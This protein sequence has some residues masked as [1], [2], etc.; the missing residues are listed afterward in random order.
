MSSTNINIKNIAKKYFDKKRHLSDLE[1]IVLL[2][3]YYNEMLENINEEDESDLDL[4]DQIIEEWIVNLFVPPEDSI[5]IE[6]A[7]LSV[8]GSK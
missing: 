8:L 2:Y 3:Y 7:A 4:Q 5:D 6:L 1:R